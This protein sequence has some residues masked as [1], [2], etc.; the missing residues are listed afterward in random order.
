MKNIAQ[1]Y[2]KI[3]ISP[4]KSLLRESNYYVLVNHCVISLKK[5]DAFRIEIR[6]QVEPY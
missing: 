4:L 3:Q 5:K 6:A 1:K 2:K